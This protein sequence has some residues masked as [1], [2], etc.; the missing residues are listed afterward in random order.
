MTLLDANLAA[1][2]ICKCKTPHQMERKLRDHFQD[3]STL[4]TRVIEAEEDYYQ[5]Q[6]I[7]VLNSGSS[8]EQHVIV[9]LS[10]AK[11]KENNWDL[12]LVSMLDISTEIQAQLRLMDLRKQER[13]LFENS[14]TGL[15]L[16]DGSNIQKQVSRL[17]GLSS[18]LRAEIDNNPDLLLQTIDGLEVLEINQTALEIFEAGS[19]ESL[20]EFLRGQFDPWGMN[21]LKELLVSAQKGNQ[22]FEWETQSLTAKGKLE[23][24]PTS[25]YFVAWI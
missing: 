7:L 17:M 15:V 5:E 12:F 22:S 20:S 4:F 2:K 1:Y 13:H 25:N 9:R 14:P 3:L 8:E 10:L 19:L 6:K 11:G 21:L 18:D 23:T 24:S 16:C